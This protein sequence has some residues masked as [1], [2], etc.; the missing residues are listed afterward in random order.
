[1]VEIQVG[2]GVDGVT[3]VLAPKYRKSIEKDL[4]NRPNKVFMGWSG[5]EDLDTLVLSRVEIVASIL[6]GLDAKQI[7]EE[8]VEVK[9]FTGLRKGFVILWSPEEIADKSIVEAT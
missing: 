8:G 5:P 6:T 9:R 2:F 4:K 3:F 1:M 7:R